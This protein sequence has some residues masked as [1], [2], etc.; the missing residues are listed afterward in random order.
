MDNFGDIEIDFA[1][2]FSYTK[3]LTYVFIPF[4]VDK[5]N[6]WHVNNLS[7]LQPG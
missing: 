5:A 2:V 3:L 4:T 7:K 1:R 6:I